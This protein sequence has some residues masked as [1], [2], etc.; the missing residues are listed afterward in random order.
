MQLEKLSRLKEHG[1]TKDKD[2]DTKLQASLAIRTPWQ[3]SSGPLMSGPPIGG[4]AKAGWHKIEANSKVPLKGMSVEMKILDIF[5]HHAGNHLKIAYKI[6]VW[7]KI[8]KLP[9]GHAELRLFN[10]CAK[11]RLR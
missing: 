4:A 11:Q 8:S 3:A 5:G 1:K 10:G 6:Q 9:K 2:D 7:T